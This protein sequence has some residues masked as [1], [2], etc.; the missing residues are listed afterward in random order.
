[1]KAGMYIEFCVLKKYVILF[2]FFYVYFFF[3]FSYCVVCKKSF[4][5]CQLSRYPNGVVVHNECVKDPRVCPLT[6]QMFT[7]Q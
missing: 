4:H 2:L 1:M 5:S 7:V 3:F 6:G